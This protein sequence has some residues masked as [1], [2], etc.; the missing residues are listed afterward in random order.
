MLI[1][2]LQKKEDLSNSEQILADFILANTLR[3]CNMSTREI[4]SE[5]FVSSAT[6]V[7]FAKKMGFD[8]YEQFKQ[9]LYA[10]WSS[11]DEKYLTIDADFPYDA[12][13]P[14]ETIFDRIAG[15]EKKAIQETKE[16]I[17]LDK[18][19][20]LIEDIAGCKAIDLYGEGVSY[21]TAHSFAS[22]MNRLGY[23]IF[24]EKD[25]ARQVHRS[26][27]LFPDH[28]NLFLSYSG[29]S[30][31]SLSIAKMLHK[32]KLKSLSI[33]SERPNQLMNQ[34][35]HHLSIARMEGKITTGGIST[36]CSTISFAFLLDLIYSC[37]LQKK[38]DENLAHIR[39]GIYA[40]KEFELNGK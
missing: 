8:S 11:T 1:Y 26:T 40:A 3:V 23:D 9:Q 24:V 32:H 31:F 38:Y 5:A 35:T 2:K 12:D 15:L 6:V 13:T 18:W 19:E 10:E 29:E 17:H 34:T 20:A 4:S 33:T 25:R 21:E 27:N 39:K 22:N 28:F 14:Y 16:M 7:R 30:N 36:I 37:V